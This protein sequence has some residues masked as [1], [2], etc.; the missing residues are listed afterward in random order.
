MAEGSQCTLERGSKVFEGS[1]LSS[2][3]VYSW[4]LAL[5]D[6]AVKHKDWELGRQNLK[7]KQEAELC[8]S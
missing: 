4:E 2:D 7:W 3:M 5:L 6:W 8:V 1:E